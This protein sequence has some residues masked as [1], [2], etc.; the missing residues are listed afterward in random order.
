MDFEKPRI[1][2]AESK[3]HL[4]KTIAGLQEEGLQYIDLFTNQADELAEL[5]SIKSKINHSD[6]FNEY[7]DQNFGCIVV[8]PWRGTFLRVLDEEDFY[9]LLTSRNKYL[10][11]ES[12]QTKYRQTNLGVAGL[13]VGS[14]IVLAVV[15]QGGC[16]N[17]KIADADEIATSNLNRII[18][19]LFSVGEDKTIAL[20][21]RLY[22]INPYIKVELFSQGI[23]N[24]NID[25]FVNNS[26]IIFDEIDSLDLKLDFRF[27]AKEKKLPI[28]MLTD[29]GDNVMVDIERYD[30]D[31]SLLPFHGLL[32]QDDITLIK[33]SNGK[34]SPRDKVVLSLKIVQ[35][36][37]A[38]PR[39]QDSL[40]EVGKSLKTWPQI[41]T[42]S[43]LAGSVGSYLVRKI[44]N[45]EKLATGRLHVSTDSYLIPDHNSDESLRERDDHTN[46]FLSHLQ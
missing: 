10:I 40:L 12:E 19:G 26:D 9:T 7:I 11:N 32:T 42:A 24:E 39:M 31:Q 45:N 35:P 4:E 2:K 5:T 1:I 3:D 23:T 28:I 30:Q 21:K 6:A 41:S 34:L 18:S 44:A 43:L 17:I 20:A 38:V 46:K 8:Y 29:N 33:E 36:Q 13:S 14:N 27:I 22:E 37:N 25:D 15:M 16:Q